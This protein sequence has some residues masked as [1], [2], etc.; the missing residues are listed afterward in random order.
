MPG[1]LETAGRGATSLEH[2]ALLRGEGLG[3][4]S[5]LPSSIHWASSV[6]QPLPRP[7][8]QLNDSLSQAPTQRLHGFL[9]KLLF[10]FFLTTTTTKD[11]PETKLEHTFRSEPDPYG[12]KKLWFKPLALEYLRAHMSLGTKTRSSSLHPPATPW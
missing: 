3:F 10:F 1:S 6:H 9:L 4:H 11:K 5:L 8:E 2:P 12:V 7:W